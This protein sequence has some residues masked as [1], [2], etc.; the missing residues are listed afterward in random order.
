MLTA[1]PLTWIQDFTRDREFFAR[2]FKLALPI[3]AQQFIMS[4]LNLVNGIMVGQ[5]GETAVAAVGLSNQIY[6]LL[7]LLLFG[8]NSGAAIFT[9]QYWGKGDV[10]SIRKVMG[11]GLVVGLAGGLLFTILGLFFPQ[12]ALGFYSTDAAV[13]TLGSSY[14]R[15]YT[16]SF[17]FTA[18]TFCYAF[19]LRSVGNVRLPMVVSMGALS[20][21]TV[22][23]YILIFGKLGL[24]AMGIN[25]A[26]VSITIARALECGVLLW[27]AYRLQTP[28]AARLSELFRFDR[29]FV[30]RVLRRV[31]PV[32]M[33]EV[34]WS[35]G[36]T[37]YNAVYAHMGTASIAAMNIAST[38]D[39]LAIVLFI[40]IGNACAIL[41]GNVIGAGDEE[42]A[43]RY[44]GKSLLLAMLGS[45]LVGAVLWASSGWLLLP[46]KVSPEVTQSAQRVLLVLSA[47]LWLRSANMVLYVGIFRSGGDTR[48]AFIMDAGIIW[49]V[50]V[51]LAL[52]GAFVFRLP[53]YWV[54]LMVMGDELTKCAVGLFRYFSRKWIHNLTVT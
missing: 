37:T 43:F 2:L 47:L 51:P 17:L 44:A 45:L 29:V 34:F 12:I 22:L 54:Y 39:G 40:G 4:S 15:I 26:A 7:N 30:G 10:A 20:L 32:M 42:K 23:G 46:Y 5:L 21:N 52:L 36:I 24:P 16:L 3:I 11:L 14:L 49:A 41:V 8:A 53:V 35:L 33:N 25:G 31:L 50:G 9:A 1:Q 28:A 13:I 18:V 27:L 38:F 6:F 48:F 19:V